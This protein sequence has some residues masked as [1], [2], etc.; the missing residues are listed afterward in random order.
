MSPRNSDSAM[1]GLIRRS[2][3]RE[4][5]SPLDPCP[6]P[7]ILAAYYDRSLESEEVARWELHF[8]Q[9]PGCREQLALIA[10]ADEKPRAEPTRGW[11]WDWR[12]LAATATVLILVISWSVRRS[13]RVASNRSSETPLLALS[14]PN[15]APAP[16]DLPVT[17]SIPSSAPPSPGD[18]PAL[19]K[20]PNREIPDTLKQESSEGD[21][22]KKLPA[23]APATDQQRPAIPPVSGRSETATNLPLN[24]R[25]DSNLQT[26]NTTSDSAPREAAPAQ[27]AEAQAKAAAQGPASAAGAA[28]EIAPAAPKAND[29]AG[30]IDKTRA[31]SE[32]RLAQP[33]TAARADDINSAAG[34]TLS[35]NVTATVAQKAEQ[36]SGQILI[37]TP[38]PKVLW[39]IAGAGFVERTTDGGATWNGQLPDPNV[40]LTGGSAPSAKVCWLVARNGAILLTKD[41][42]K[43][44]KIAPPVPADFTAVTAKSASNATVTTADG[45]KFSTIDGGKKW[46]PAP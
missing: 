21:A 28:P 15:P 31:S 19:R 41:A 30:A 6:A 8:S 18:A 2:L 27:N 39:R 33:R 35:A 45:Q 32:A 34:T 4:E 46:K 26:A 43:W 23:P 42:V 14:E 7:E 3:S 24:G 12:W 37:S 1:G 17:P 25:N 16:N 22:E 40:Q 13:E 20:S 36:V 38:D 5:R 9:C 29:A 11:S 10:R 44:K